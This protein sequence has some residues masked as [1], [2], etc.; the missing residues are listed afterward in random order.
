MSPSILIVGATGNTGRSVVSTL[1]ELIKTSKHLANT[2]LIAQS[3]SASSSSAKKLAS[4]PNVSILEKPWVDIT[5]DWYRENEVTKVFIASHNEP[6]AFAEESHF[7][8]TALNGRVKHV[9]RISTTAANVHPN[10]KAYYPRTH[11]AIEKMLESEEFKDMMWTSLQPNVF[12]SMVLGNAVALVKE[13]RKTGKQVPL[14]LIS[15]KDA[16]VGIIDSND[17]GAFAAHVLADENPEKH[18]GKRY[19][20]NGSQDITGQQIVDM[21]EKEL[22][23]PVEDVKYQDISFLEQLYEGQQRTIVMSIKHAVVT[24][25][26]GKCGIDTTSKEVPGIYSPKMTPAQTFKELLEE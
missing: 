1:T 11:W 6:P 9:V 4:I 16:G 18:N 10:S 24:A 14:R 21:V 5:S 7:H 17:V 20:L 2:H 25:W 19:V 23:V 8:V 15:S 12:T 22:G 26:E 3:R 13:Y